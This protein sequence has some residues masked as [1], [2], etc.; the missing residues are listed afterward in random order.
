MTADGNFHLNKYMKN[1][2]PNDVSLYNGR[3]YF[4]NE[5]EFQ[6]YLKAQPR[7]LPEVRINVASTLMFPSLVIRLQKVVCDHLKAIKNRQRGGKKFK[8]LDVT[9]VV[10][11]QCS[12]IN[13][14]ST[15][16]LQ[17]GERYIHLITVLFYLLI[18]SIQIRKYRLWLWPCLSNY[19]TKRCLPEPSIRSQGRSQKVLRH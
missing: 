9:G 19:E 12:H 13:I 3:A 2:D 5:E 8:N 11:I 16:D 10:N 6:A 7:D 15:V 18:F 1:T 14:K 17:A 4:P